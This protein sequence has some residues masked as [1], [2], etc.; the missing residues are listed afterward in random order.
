MLTKDLFPTVPQWF[1]THT[2]PTPATP[3]RIAT[4]AEGARDTNCT[5]TAPRHCPN[6]DSGR[7]TPR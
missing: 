7:A 2:I 6:P 5:T 3:A 1:P 4:I